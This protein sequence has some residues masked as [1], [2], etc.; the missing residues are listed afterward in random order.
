VAAVAVW[1]HRPTPQ[2]LLE[3]RLAS[4][5][6]PTP[7]LLKEGEKVLG[8]AACVFDNKDLRA[9]RTSGPSAGA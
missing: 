1:N 6:K 8:Y 9:K 7:S 2:E 5:W 4:G 3:A